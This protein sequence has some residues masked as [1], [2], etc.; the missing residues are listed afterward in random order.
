MFKRVME[1]LINH[2]E[3]YSEFMKEIMYWDYQYFENVCFNKQLSI[4]ENLYYL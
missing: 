4:N 2:K 3:N 1:T